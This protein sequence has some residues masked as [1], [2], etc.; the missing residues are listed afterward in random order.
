M[1]LDGVPYY[2]LFIFKYHLHYICMIDSKESYR[3]QCSYFQ[4][5]NKVEAIVKLDGVPYYELFIFKCLHVN[6]TFV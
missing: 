5:D 2:G 4:L 3:K 6:I 1:K